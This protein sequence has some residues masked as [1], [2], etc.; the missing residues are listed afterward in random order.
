MLHAYFCDRILIRQFLV[1]AG[2]FLN[3]NWRNR[4]TSID[5]FSKD[6]DYI[7]SIDENGTSS[8]KKVDEAKQKNVQV[9]DYEKHFVVTAC[10]IKVSDFELARDKVMSLKEKYWEN[11]LFN[12]D[13]Q[14]KR[15]C[16]H[17]REIRNKKDAFD[18][19]VINYECFVADLSGLIDSL[20]IVVYSSYINK[21]NHVKKYKY[22]KSPYDLCMNFVLERIMHDIGNNKKCI[23]V[24]EARGKDEDKALL[25]Q[26]KALIDNGNQYN[27][28]SLFAKI[29]GVYFNPKWSECSHCQK[30]Y[31]ALEIADLCS[32]PIY[33]IFAHKKKDRS[34][35]VVE[36]KINGY[37]TYIG[38]G[39]KT[40][41]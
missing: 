18:P 26:I 9:P 34:F 38:K 39:L 22:P 15:V 30:S 19:N 10:V 11:A 24:L 33:K 21:E 29:K 16:F 7:I 5:Y 27:P 40:F 23:V 17:S 2:E 4:P 41:P 28:A 6:I 20:P 14:D 35:D 1:K 36:K 25:K 8:L 31:W 37:P 12:Y 13:G 32:Y 3:S